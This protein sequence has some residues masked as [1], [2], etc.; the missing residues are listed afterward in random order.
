MKPLRQV[1]KLEN[2]FP[3]IWYVTNSFIVLCPTP[4]RHVIFRNLLKESTVTKR[5]ADTAGG[6]LINI[7]TILVGLTVGASTRFQ[8]S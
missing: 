1:S 5:L 6:P 7:A 4:F 8:L 2:S 3:N